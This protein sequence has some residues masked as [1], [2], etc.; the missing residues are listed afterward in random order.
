LGTTLQSS[1]EVRMLEFLK[2]SLAAIELLTILYGWLM[3]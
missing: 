1:K 2:F 3:R